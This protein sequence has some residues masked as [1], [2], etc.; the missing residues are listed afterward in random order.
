MKKGAGKT[1]CR[2][3]T[4]G[5]L[6]EGWQQESA[7]RHTGVAK[8]SGLP[9]AV[10]GTAYVALSPGSDAL[11][12]PSPRGWLMRQPGWA[13][14]ITAGLGAQTP[15]A[16]TTRFYRTRTAPV[17]CAMRSAHGCPPCEA[18]RA[19]VARVH[20]RPAR[21]RDDRDTPSSLGRVMARHTPFPNFW[22][23]EYFHNEGLTCRSGV[24]PVGQH[25]G[26]WMH[27]A[28]RPGANGCCAKIDP[29]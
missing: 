14:D 17:V 9:C 26:L 24:L 10:V 22:K 3:G 29:H 6:C 4:H 28:D 12:P 11:L 15:G 5:P 16:R 20:R 23:V 2:P 13:A 1:G 25:K 21:V 18:N 19:D 7:Q 27:R 8:T